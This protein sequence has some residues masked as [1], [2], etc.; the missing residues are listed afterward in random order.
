MSR[1]WA[2]ATALW[3]EVSALPTY[4]DS[5]TASPTTSRRAPRTRGSDRLTAYLIAA[6]HE[7]AL[8]LAG[9]ARDA[10]LDGL[11]AFVE[12]RIAR[13]FWSPAF[14]KAD[15][16][17]RKIAALE[18]LP[19]PGRARRRCSEHQPHAQPVADGG[20]DRLARIL[21]RVEGHP[22]ARQAHREGAAGAA[23][24]PDVRR[25]PRALSS[26]EEDFWWWLMDSADANAAADPRHAGRAG[27][28]E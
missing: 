13:E 26:E 18:A 24:A 2:C 22:R 4:L 3:A 8:R 14:A 6:T 11:V 7:A 17:V 12:G 28:E 15:L 23:R 9:A 1:P 10:M 21:K 16:D 25:A 5:A 19:S 20:G 27:L